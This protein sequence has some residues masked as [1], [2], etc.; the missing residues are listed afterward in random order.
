MGL[1][2]VCRTER[3]TIRK[4]IV[5]PCTIGNAE[6]VTFSGLSDSG[7]HIAILYGD[8]EEQ[9]SP[10]VRIHSECLTGDIFGSAR[11]DCGDQ[12]REAQE[13]FNS[14]GG[15]LIY[16]RQE[17]RGIGLYNKMD[18]YD[19]Q[20]SGMNTYQANEALGFKK[21]ERNYLVAAQMLQALGIGSIRLLSNNPEKRTSMEACGVRVDGRI[22]TSVFLK[23]TNHSYLKAKAEITHHELALKGVLV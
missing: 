8:W 21:D 6:F 9:E 20:D 19:L 18:A 15:V 22:C 17:G 12:L 2:F 11:C 7:E 4:K 16:L 14:A 5:I 10:L 23:P 1:S 3:V 13:M